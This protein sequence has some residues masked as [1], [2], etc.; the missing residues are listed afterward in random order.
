MLA[1]HNTAPR[2]QRPN[3]TLHTILRHVR[4]VEHIVKTL[5]F[6]KRPWQNKDLEP[7][8]VRAVNF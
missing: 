3:T 7:F 5:G 8:D 4:S 6:V 2:N 1:V